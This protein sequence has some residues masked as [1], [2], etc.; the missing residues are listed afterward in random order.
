M[1][2]AQPN[3]QHKTDYPYGI[4]LRPP[5]GW[6]GPVGVPPPPFA[7][8]KLSKPA[9]PTKSA[10]TRV[11]QT[12]LRHKR[13]PSSH[14]RGLPL[15]AALMALMVMACMAVGW[16]SVAGSRARQTPPSPVLADS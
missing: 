4:P 2:D 5:P 12:A 11:A 9:I 8:Q 7:L 6:R 16:L 13:P 10:P 14:G 3:R 15:Q 1:A